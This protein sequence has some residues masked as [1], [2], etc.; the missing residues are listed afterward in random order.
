[1]ALG[2]E[3]PLALMVAQLRERG[4][5]R[6]PS[7][8]RRVFRRFWA[9][10]I[11]SRRLVFLSVTGRLTRGD[12]GFE[13]TPAKTCRHEWRHGTSGDARHV[14]CPQPSCSRSLVTT[15]L[16]P[17]ERAGAETARSKTH[18]F[19]SF[20]VGRKQTGADQS[21]EATASSRSRLRLG[22]RP[23]GTPSRSHQHDRART[24]GGGVRK[25]AEPL[26]Q[27]VT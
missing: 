18:G 1:M 20:W 25:M 6:L 4:L 13:V 10:L 21:V 15:F 19:S 7:C 5:P 14:A 24:R 23:M 27:I 17:T 22:R 9:S 26:R 8:F 16:V 2:C 11:H 12:T 3:W